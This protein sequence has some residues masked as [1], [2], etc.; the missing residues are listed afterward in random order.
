M[1]HSAAGQFPHVGSHEPRATSDAPAV[2]GPAGRRALRR[3]LQQ[4][5]RALGLRRTFS[6][7]GILYRERSGESLGRAL[8]KNGRGFKDFEAIFPDGTHLRIRA[9]AQ[10]VFA[11][12]SRPARMQRYVRLGDFVRPGARL[13][14]IGCS[15]GYGTAWLA[16]R[17]GVA[18][19]VVAMDSDEDAVAYAHKRHPLPNVSFELR[20]TDSLSGE[21]DGAFDG[22][23]CLRDEESLLGEG[24]AAELWRVVAPGGW[25][26]L[27]VPASP[28]IPPDTI[29]TVLDAA[30]SGHVRMVK[31]IGAPL[32]RVQDVLLVKAEADQ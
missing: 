21:I 23:V 8:G 25:L 14:E 1:G 15:T 19:A 12:L 9:T 2:A 18:G 22:V 17:T 11:D 6:V 7:D 4:A 16:G 30:R 31:Q 20:C 32:G 28:G 27:G 26:V 3:W 13:L 29:G 5:Q 10:R 24:E